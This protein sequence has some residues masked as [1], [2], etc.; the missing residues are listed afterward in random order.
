MQLLLPQSPLLKG[1]Q[2]GSLPGEGEG[3]ELVQKN[4]S[5]FKHGSSKGK[6]ASLPFLFLSACL[7]LS[8]PLLSVSFDHLF[9]QL[10][11]TA[12][13]EDW[14]G[15]LKTSLSSRHLLSS[16]VGASGDKYSVWWR[17]IPGRKIKQRYSWKEKGDLLFLKRLVG[18]SLSDDDLEQRSGFQAEEGQVQGP[19]ERIWSLRGMLGWRQGRSGRALYTYVYTRVLFC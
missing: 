15:H 19:W 7:C 18:K 4:H 9:S 1:S 3:E 5:H 2:A 8:L 16:G 11:F 17:Q 10:V 6:P 12:G 13:T 14:E